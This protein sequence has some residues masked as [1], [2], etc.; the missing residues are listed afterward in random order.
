MSLH[1]FKNICKGFM[2]ISRNCIDLVLPAD[3]IL[4]MQI[5][6]TRK[7]NRITHHVGAQEGGNT[8][9]ITRNAFR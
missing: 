6:I 8:L 4:N 7:M 3:T 9:S 5:S 2:T 1:P